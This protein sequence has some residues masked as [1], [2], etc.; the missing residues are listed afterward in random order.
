MAMGIFSAICG[1]FHDKNFDKNG[2]I[3]LDENALDLINNHALKLW[4]RKEY[5]LYRIYLNIYARE[6]LGLKRE[7]RGDKAVFH[8][9][10]KEISRQDFELLD[11]WARNSFYDCIKHCVCLDFRFEQYVIGTPIEKIPHEWSPDLDPYSLK[12]LGFIQDDEDEEDDK[13]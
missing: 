7:G 10:D 11:S 1:L 5:K 3:I 8:Y 4:A 9:K 12:S 6:V 13:Y 2:N